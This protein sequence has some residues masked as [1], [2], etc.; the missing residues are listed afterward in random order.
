MSAGQ[1]APLRLSRPSTV[2]AIA[3]AL[4]KR[5]LAGEYK[6]G[7]LMRESTLAR[8][9]QVSRPTAREALQRLAREGLLT[10]Q[11]HR[12]MV[13]TPL[14]DAD[15]KDIYWVRGVLECAGVSTRN[16]RQ[17]PLR[18]AEESVAAF[19]AAVS[20]SD[21]LRAVDADMSFHNALVA[22]TGSQRLVEMHA[23]ITAELRLALG[24]MDLVSGDAQRQAREHQEMLRDVKTGLT[25]IAI[26][27]V[28]GHL[29]RACAQLIAFVY[30]N[31]R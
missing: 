1:A 31:E 8:Q 10:Y 5:L 25:D 26:A 17:S 3:N 9:L 22:L 20:A 6:L 14:S 19:E 28:R 27:H 4:R 11:L 29:D 24:R 7:E 2:D 23:G 15:I 18:A 16:R 30:D 12:G 13:V 21:T